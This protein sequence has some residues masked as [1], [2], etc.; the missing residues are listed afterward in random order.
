GPSRLAGT[1]KRRADYSV[2]L[3][4]VSSTLHGIFTAADLCDER[5]TCSHSRNGSGAEELSQS[6][7]CSC[8]VPAWRPGFGSRTGVFARYHGARF[9][10]CRTD[11]GSLRGSL[12]C[13]GSAGKKGSQEQSTSGHTHSCRQW[14]TNYM[15][16]RQYLLDGCRFAVIELR[17][18][19]TVR[20]ADSGFAGSERIKYGYRAHVFCSE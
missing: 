13:S 5:N 15:S 10:D 11:R 20:K 16:R 9:S 4:V 7:C 3:R 19:D 2:T 18:S 8:A 14:P 1:S 17:R 6:R 12:R